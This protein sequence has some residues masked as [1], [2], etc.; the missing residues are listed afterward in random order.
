[1]NFKPEY[2]VPAIILIVVVVISLCSSCMDYFNEGYDNIKGKGVSFSE[3][4]NGQNN[5][6]QQTYAPNSVEVSATEQTRSNESYNVETTPSVADYETT[7]APEPGYA[8]TNYE[9]TGA[10]EPEYANTNYEPT[11]AQW[12]VVTPEVDYMESTTPYGTTDRDVTVGEG[13]A[14]LEQ[15]YSNY[16]KEDQI[17]IYSTAKGNMSCEPNSYSNSTGYLCLD[18]KQKR[19]LM[20]RGMNQSGTTMQIGQA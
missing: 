18:D 15:V 20:T 5:S 8:N 10:P 14:T 17:D 16:G 4:N 2:F 1:M 11:G 6:V 12:D 19:L 3:Y 13:F 9:P 7:G